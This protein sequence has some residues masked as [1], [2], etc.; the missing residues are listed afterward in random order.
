MNFELFFTRRTLK[1]DKN[2]ISGPYVKI[3]II[4]IALG[5]AVMI[6]SVAIVT[7]F[8]KEIRNKVV[9]FGA[10]IQVTSYDFNRS[11]ESTPI[12]NNNALRQSIE[13]VE[14]VIHTQVFASK[15]GIIKTEDAIQGIIMKGIGPDYDWSFFQDKIREG[16]TFIVND[17]SRTDFVLISWKLAG[18]L[19]LNLGDDLRVYFVGT[20]SHQ[21]RGRKFTIHGIYETGLEE[22]DDT[23][24]I[25]DINHIRRLNNWSD[26]QIA[27]YE[28]MVDD[29]GRV[30][31]LSD[32][33]YN[34]ID[35]DLRA[36]NIGEMY[37]QI[38]DWLNLQD[39]NVVVI[40]VL[41]ILVSGITMISTLMVLI[42]ERVNTIGLLKG[43]GAKDTSI[44]KI[45]MYHSVYIIGI[46]MFWGNMVGVGI[47]LIQ[48]YTRLIPLSEESYYVS[49][50]PVHLDAVSI[51]L[52]NAGTLIVCTAMLLI[53]SY[54]IARITPLKAIRLD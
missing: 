13:N 42:L 53:P 40:I 54:I 47:S 51:L 30:E 11:V 48:Y 3:A 1:K 35:Y 26:N 5:L 19:D 7:G 29:F 28:V 33:I 2:N 8:Q 46:G 23:Y 27:G 17:S 20:D 49:Y 10:H 14:G 25:G 18:L 22:F 50:V 44:R 4:A 21:P 36:T 39:M 9:G 16:N 31:E 41:M 32:I 24:I 43:L 38:F 6:V 45:F 52:L 12:E 15:A 37:P 34:K